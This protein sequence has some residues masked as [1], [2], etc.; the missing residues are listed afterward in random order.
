[1]M[2]VMD[3]SGMWHAA[4]AGAKIEFSRNKP[5]P[6]ECAKNLKCWWFGEH[7]SVKAFMRWHIKSTG[8]AAAFC[9]SC[10]KSTE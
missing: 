5:T 9:Q 2:F 1:M 8:K 6:T 7:K 3:T 4:K 10:R